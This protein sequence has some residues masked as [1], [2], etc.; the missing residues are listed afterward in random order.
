M[1]Y[2]ERSDWY[3]NLMVSGTVQV[4]WQGQTYKAE[5]PE[6]LEVGEAEN[7]FPAVSRFLFELDG[8]PGFVRVTIID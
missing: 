1:T 2:G 4:T 3:Q 5:N 6:R 7:D 8:L